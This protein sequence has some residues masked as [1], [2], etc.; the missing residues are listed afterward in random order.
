MNSVPS[1][2]LRG[3]SL[4]SI[5]PDAVP[6]KSEDLLICS[7]AGDVAHCQ[8]GD[9]F[10]AI[11][12][13]DDDGH[14]HALDAVEKG[15]IGI[16][17]E[18]LL[19]VDI[20]QF[21]VD[22]SR[23]ALAEICQALAGHP[24]GLLTTIGVAGS[25]GKTVT[26]EL[27]SRVIEVA[28]GH[29]AKSTS[30]DHTAEAAARPAQSPHQESAPRIARWLV[31]AVLDHSSHCV[32][33][34][35]TQML[36]ERQLHAMAFDILVLT[37][38][39]RDESNFERNDETYRQIQA[40][41]L[42]YLKPHGM[43]ILNADDPLSQRLLDTLQVP[44]LTFGINQA[45]EVTAKLIERT[46]C[47]QTFLITA[48][49]ETIVVTTPMIGLQHVYNCLAATTVGLA[50]GCE[51]TEIAKGLESVGQ[52]VGRLE[53]I[54]THGDARVII[55]AARRSTPVATAIHAVRQHARGPLWVLASVPPDMNTTEARRIGEVL[56]KTA[57]RILLAPPDGTCP[58]NYEPFHRVIDGIADPTKVQTILNRFRA[59][60]WLL[61]QA[62]AGGSVL[63]L[64]N[65][66]RRYP[67]ASAT[68]ELVDDR[69]VCETWLRE[70]RSFGAALPAPQK[71]IFRL[72][73]YRGES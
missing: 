56:S 23:R 59:I 65:G 52:I 6:Y 24:A 33:E 15:A 69:T 38:I 46:P 73:D 14:D 31:D 60:E 36:A 49:H 5:L 50:L 44:A 72:T 22:D 41:S 1:P 71:S 43:A 10:V 68:R 45:A 42:D 18:R 39:R 48:G 63:I 8:A 28:G 9:L 66:E 37:N 47:E 21:I 64:G 19:A 2:A 70:R 13:A 32:L 62:P 55:D 61:D 34:I 54:P 11:V 53:P 29:V 4:I 67:S 3:L 57:D 27:I 25:D 58:P 20:P 17:T 40:R 30:L 7:C 16:V 26:C 35:G 12:S 51:L